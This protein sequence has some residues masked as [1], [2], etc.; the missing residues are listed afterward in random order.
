M[1]HI[2]DFIRRCEE[3]TGFLCRYVLGMDYDEAEGPHGKERINEGSGGIRKDGP[4][5]LMTDFVDAPKPRKMLQAPRGSY[6]SSII[7]G[8]VIREIL[9]NPNARIALGMNKKDNAGEKA[10]AIRQQLEF[11]PKIKRFWGDQVGDR[12]ES[13]RFTVAGR[14]DHSLMEPTVTCFSLESPITGGHYDLVILD[15][16]V[17]HLNVRTREGIEKTQVVWQQCSPLMVQGGQLIVIGTRYHHA[18][19]Y[20]EIEDNHPYYDKLIL[21]CGMEVEKD[22]EK[23]IYVLRGTPLFPHLTK[24]RLDTE[25]ATGFDYFMC[26][27]MNRVSMGANQPFTRDMFKNIRL[28]QLKLE[29]MSGYILTD[30][31]VSEREEGCY[32]VIAY[33]CLDEAD[34][35]YLLDMRVGHWHIKQFEEHFFEML[36]YWSSKTNHRAEVF[37]KI[38]YNVALCAGI[39]REASRRGIRTHIV[40]SSRKSSDQSKNQRI[41]RLQSR[42]QNGKFYVADSV[43]RFYT[44]IEKTGIQTLY[45]PEKYQKNTEMP[46]P[47]GELVLEFINFPRWPKKDIPDA[48]ADI[49]ERLQDGKKLCPWVSPRVTSTHRQLRRTTGYERDYSRTGSWWDQTYRDIFHR[50]L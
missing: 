44:D 48:L 12:W 23:G 32:N 17:D 6:K 39:E 38:A 28:G 19:L 18:D 45:D 43:P 47:D 2:E 4:H 22:E 15:D 10:R 7:Q 37:E 46:L 11:N 16:I 29:K 36:T 14:T 40:H 3:D 33:G 34:N 24:E 21:D 13:T 8:R 9:R 50:A 49:D 20:G 42:F 26:Q 1:S 25:L 35:F 30:T 41:M 27:Y 5:R 31:A